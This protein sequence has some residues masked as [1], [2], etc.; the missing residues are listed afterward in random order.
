MDVSFSIEVEFEVSESE[1]KT[2]AIFVYASNK[3]KTRMEQWQELLDRKGDWGN[4]WILGEDFNDI[5]HPSEKA[6]GRT[7]TE[8]SCQGFRK[9]IEQ[10]EIEEIMFQGNNVPGSCIYIKVRLDGSCIYISSPCEKAS[11]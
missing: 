6:G 5:R 10:M 1:G 7:R 9:F 2:W 11:V 3:E 4:K 8:A